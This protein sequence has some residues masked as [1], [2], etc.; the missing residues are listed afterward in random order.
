MYLQNRE[1]GDTQPNATSISWFISVRDLE[2]R[3]RNAGL[4]E[5]C[6]NKT[7]KLKERKLKVS[8]IKHQRQINSRCCIGVHHTKLSFDCLNDQIM[9]D[10]DLR[11]AGNQL[12]LAVIWEKIIHKNLKNGLHIKK[13]INKQTNNLRGICK[14]KLVKKSTVH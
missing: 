9:D 10:Y 5:V 13:S 14:I 7:D 3:E 11:F 6:V 12:Y 8:L 2:E 4:Q 1:K